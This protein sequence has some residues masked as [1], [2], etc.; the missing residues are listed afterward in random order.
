MKNL[1]LNRIL[2]IV[3]VVIL[4]L[5]TYF[6]ENLLLEINALIEGH[7]YD[8]SYSYWFASFFKGL[9]KAELYNWKWGISIF[10]SLIIPIITLL[11][12]YGWFK[13]KQLLKLLSIIYVIVFTFMLLMTSF[14]YV[15][16]IFDDIY[17]VLR[18][19]IGLLQSPLPFFLFFLLFSTLENKKS[20]PTFGSSNS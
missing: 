13:S 20:K 3:G 4:L 10:F 16:G 5:G 11:T 9:N 15:F 8:R 1:I 19:I 18:K 2:V 17:F 7:E 12:L 14:S 6:R